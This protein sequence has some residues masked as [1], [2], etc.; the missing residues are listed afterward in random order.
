ML[1]SV[2]NH[3]QTASLRFTPSRRDGLCRNRLPTGGY[4]IEP[5]TPPPK[6]SRRRWLIV[7]FVLVLVST[8]AWW[9]WPRGDARFVGRWRL[10]GGNLK[11]PIGEMT[12]DRHGG[13]EWPEGPSKKQ[14]PWTVSNGSLVIGHAARPMHWWFLTDMTAWMTGRPRYYAGKIRFE[15]RSVGQDRI[16]TTMHW[17]DQ[18]N[19]YEVVFTRIPE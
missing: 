13:G 16:V 19:P 5:S 1:A 2:K 17:R 15:I 3:L 12:F 9:N 4:P 7:A 6:R 10:S 14:F 8:V 18:G 11:A